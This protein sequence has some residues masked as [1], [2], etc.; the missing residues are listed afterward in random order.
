MPQ[1]NDKLNFVLNAAFNLD[2]LTE[3]RLF[4]MGVDLNKEVTTG[5]LISTGPLLDVLIDPSDVVLNEVSDGIEFSITV[6]LL[7]NVSA[8]K[9]W[10][11]ANVHPSINR[12]FFY[13]NYPNTYNLENGY[14]ITVSGK[15][16]Y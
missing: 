8:V 1:P 12:V 2:L 7:S 11:I 10:A 15:S 6:V 5:D 13:D 3:S 14:T 9:S 16:Y 4:L